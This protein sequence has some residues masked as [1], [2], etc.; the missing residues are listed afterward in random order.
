M[1]V[2]RAPC[3]LPHGSLFQGGGD[4]GNTLCV[5]G[6]RRRESLWSWG[7]TRPEG[8][9]CGSHNTG[10]TGLCPLCIVL[11]PKGHSSWW[12]PAEAVPAQ[13]LAHMMPGKAKWQRHPLR[14]SLVPQAA[15]HP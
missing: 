13:G 15:G 1:R 11:G 2:F 8:V 4:A 14:R 12:G 9:S 10:P 6:S 3:K 7:C 5:G